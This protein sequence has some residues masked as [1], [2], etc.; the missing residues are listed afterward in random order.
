[1]GGCCGKREPTKNSLDKIAKDNK[2]TPS[3]VPKLLE[4]SNTYFSSRNNSQFYLPNIFLD[5]D[6]K[7]IVL[8]LSKD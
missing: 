2:L 6:H 7:M 5:P 3:E 1:M 4:Y 8:N